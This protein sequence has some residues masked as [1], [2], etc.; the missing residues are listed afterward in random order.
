MNPDP[1]ASC[2][3]R[4]ACGAAPPNC[5]RSIRLQGSSTAKRRM[6]FVLWMVTTAPFTRSTSGA[7]VPGSAP[8]PAAPGGAAARAQVAARLTAINDDAASRIIGRQGDRHLVAE[9]H[10][11]AMFAQFSTE[12]GEHLMAVLELDAEISRREHL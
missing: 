10:A 12:M 5:S 1:S 3:S 8:P 2:F 6:N 11:N 9:N 4:V 7:T